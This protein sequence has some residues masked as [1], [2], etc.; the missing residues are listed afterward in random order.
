LEVSGA[1]RHEER[2]NGSGK[3]EG[4]EIYIQRREKKKAM[5]KGL[6]GK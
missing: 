5:K 6:F 4:K 1:R 2:K 3:S